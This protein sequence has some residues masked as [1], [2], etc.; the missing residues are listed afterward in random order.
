MSGEQTHFFGDG[1]RP[2]HGD[3]RPQ[4]LRDLMYAKQMVEGTNTVHIPSDVLAAAQ[5]VLVRA[6]GLDVETPHGRDTARRFVQMLIELTTPEEY[7][8]TTFPADYDEMIIV[9]DITFVSLCNHHVVPFNG[10]AH[11]GY[12]PD[13]RMAGLSKFARAVKY[14]SASLQVQE[15]LTSDIAEFLNNVLKPKGVIVMMEAEHLCMT[16]RGVQSPGAMTRTTC[17]K[18]VFADHTKTAKAEFLSAINSPKR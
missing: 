2:A 3:G 14:F 13:E 15:E 8:F 5:T 17:V 1:C 18:G 16:I 10:V 4:M 7:N 11:I 12:V 6:A 9:R